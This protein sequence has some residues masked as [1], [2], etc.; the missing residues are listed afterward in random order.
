[1]FR[2]SE[3]LI[4]LK[5]NSG[6]PNDPEPRDVPR[7]GSVGVRGC[8]S[9]AFPQPPRH[10]LADFSRASWCCA[11]HLSASTQPRSRRWNGPRPRRRRTGNSFGSFCFA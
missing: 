4:V 11:V 9:A 2:A 1:V 10:V 3:S 5:K 8:L 7:H 6:A